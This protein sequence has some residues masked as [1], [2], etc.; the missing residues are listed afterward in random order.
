MTI[1]QVFLCRELHQGNLSVAII[2]EVYGFLQKLRYTV[3]VILE[4]IAVGGKK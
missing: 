2:I 1:S 4:F 3:P